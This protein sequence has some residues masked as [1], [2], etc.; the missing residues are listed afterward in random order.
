MRER[1][2]FMRFR[3][4]LEADYQARGSSSAAGRAQV[5][6]FSREGMRVAVPHP[7]SAGERVEFTMQVP[8]DAVPIVAMGEVAWAVASGIGI[9]FRQIK[10]LD[11]ARMLDYLYARWL[12]A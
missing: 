8:G 1:R 5:Q 11:L 4:N 7:L 6:D 10:P 12:G 9:R 3:A 2:R